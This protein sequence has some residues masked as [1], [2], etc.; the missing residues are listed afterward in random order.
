MRAERV[1]I[2]VDK[3]ACF[4][5]INTWRGKSEATEIYLIPGRYHRIDSRD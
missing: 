4:F 2:R 5:K 3:Q 1:G